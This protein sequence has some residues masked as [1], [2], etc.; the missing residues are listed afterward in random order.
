MER[1]C[2]RKMEDS[3]GNVVSEGQYED[4][5]RAQSARIVRKEGGSGVSISKTNSSVRILGN[6]F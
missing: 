6:E 3:K 1:M 5:L 4:C 2:E